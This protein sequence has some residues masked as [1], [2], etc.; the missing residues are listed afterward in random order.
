MRCRE[1]KYSW[2]T[3]EL[4]MTR[5]AV[6]WLQIVFLPQLPDESIPFLCLF[7]S[8]N[9]LVQRQSPDWSSIFLLVSDGKLTSY[10]VYSASRPGFLG[11]RGWS[12]HVLVPQWFC[13]SSISCRVFPY[14][15]LP[16]PDGRSELAHRVAH[17][18]R[19]WD[20]TSDRTY[21]VRFLIC[22]VKRH[23]F[24]MWMNLEAVIQ[25]EVSQKE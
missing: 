20:F 12:S 11:E 14:H 22:D 8:R 25:K 9:C 1:F 24:M 15:H 19:T 23:H 17:R 7:I 18:N 16:H 13:G 3:S 21:E 4:E 2:S 5:E 10:S 6:I